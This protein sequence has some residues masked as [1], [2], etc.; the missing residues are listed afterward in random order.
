LDDSTTFSISEGIANS[1][2]FDVGTAVILPTAHLDDSTAF[3]RSGAS[4]PLP[5]S[6]TIG[7]SANFDVGTAVILPTAHL[8]DSASHPRSEIIGISAEFNLRSD[9]ILPRSQL[10]CSATLPIS[11][12]IGSARFKTSLLIAMSD[13]LSDSSI[14]FHS[15]RQWPDSVALLFSFGSASRQFWPSTGFSNSAS[16]LQ[17]RFVGFSILRPSPSFA[18]SV[19]ISGSEPCAASGLK[20]STQI[21]RS[22]L[23]LPSRRFVV[24]LTFARFTQQIVSQVD[25]FSGEST[26]NTPALSEIVGVVSPSNLPLESHFDQGIKQPTSSTRLAIGLAV[27]LFLVLAVVGGIAFLLLTRSR[28]E[29][30]TTAETEFDAEDEKVDENERIVLFEEWSESMSQNALP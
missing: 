1:A 30:Y 18:G 14:I 8:H 2:K 23:P 6:Q 20:H 29:Y 24:S 17:S 28:N 15:P 16:L 9:L 4:A 22:P 7:N 25:S 21:S 12:G 13:Y 11:E 3:A 10:D 5:S 19:L 27:G 26:I